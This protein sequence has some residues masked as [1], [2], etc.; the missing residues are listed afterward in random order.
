MR[1]K[2]EQ[3]DGRFGVQG[4]RLPVE[5]SRFRLLVEVSGFRF[6]GWNHE[7]KGGGVGQEERHP[8]ERGGGVLGRA[9]EEGQRGCP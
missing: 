8:L 5:C 6:Q 7:G 4:L 1:E 2:E 3:A 9:K